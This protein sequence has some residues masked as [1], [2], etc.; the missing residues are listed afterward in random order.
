MGKKLATLQKNNS[1]DL[2]RLKDQD[3]DTLLTPERRKL[4]HDALWEITETD[5]FLIEKCNYSPR[6]LARLFDKVATLKSQ[7]DSADEKLQK[8]DTVNDL[9]MPGGQ[10]ASTT[11]NK[12]TDFAA[13]AAKL[14]SRIER[15]EQAFDRIAAGVRLR[16]Q[17]QHNMKAK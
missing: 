17:L 12:L 2:D 11:Y 6:E 5:P 16:A 15:C 1:A 8:L 10:Y 14:T 13:E 4:I 7:L 3:L 9:R